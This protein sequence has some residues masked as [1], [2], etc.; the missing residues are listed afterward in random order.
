MSGRRQKI[1]GDAAKSTKA[2]ADVANEALQD[3]YERLEALERV[4]WFDV[5]MVT[6]AAQNPTPIVLAAAPW[7]VKGVFLAKAFN[8]TTSVPAPSLRITHDLS[9]AGV[10]VYVFSGDTSPSTK[11]A[12]RLKVCG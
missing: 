10:N 8:K 2:L 6:D 4:A 12:L 7:P 1:R 11:Y 9:S 3:I 5:E